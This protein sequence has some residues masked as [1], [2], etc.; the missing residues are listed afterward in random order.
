MY[1]SSDDPDYGVF[2]Y[3][4]E[5][6]LEKNETVITER[7]VISGRAKS[8]LDKLNKYLRFYTDILR[9]YRKGDFDIVYLHFIS[10]SAPGLLLAKILFG[11]K[12][13]F[14]VNVHGSDIVIHHRGILKYCNDKL[15]KQTDLLV[16]PSSYFRKTI[17]KVFPHFPENKIY[18]SPSGGIDSDRFHHQPQRENKEPLHLGF[19]SRIEN[20]KG[21][22]TFIEALHLLE[23][24]SIKFK[25]SLAG[26]GSKTQDLKNLITAYKLESK[27]NYLGV[28]PQNKL[29]DLY[30]K[31]DL[32]IF[33]TLSKE[34][35][36]LVGLEAMTCATPVIGSKLAGLQTFIKDNENGFFFTPGN[37]KELAKKIE[38]YY[39][40]PEN[41]K[42]NMQQ[43]AQKTALTYDKQR[44]IKRLV[45][46]FTQLLTKP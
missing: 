24:D 4:I 35:L 43:Q 21:W 17:K 12:K 28:L 38:F 27:V 46:R 23:L 5:K 34:S 39:N 13:K 9:S 8:R 11:K 25:A 30:N 19:V 31:I 22:Q 3:N 14:V 18:I 20:E 44:V 16:V 32:F 36:G 37:E 29:N 15:L 6:A 26:T 2:V 1:P 33:P 45:Q 10:H 40:L 42:N 7:A 41:I